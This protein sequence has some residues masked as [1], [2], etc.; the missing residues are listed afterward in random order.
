MKTHFFTEEQ[1]FLQTLFCH[2]TAMNPAM[3][4]CVFQNS[5]SLAP[6]NETNHTHDTFGA[7]YYSNL[8]I[9]KQPSNQ[10]SKK[11]KHG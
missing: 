7:R 3:K 1:L 8:K 4:V 2:E 9:C 5:Y 10:A 11:A 6:L